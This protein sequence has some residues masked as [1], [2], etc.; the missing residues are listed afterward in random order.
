MHPEVPY[1]V[2]INEAVELAKVLGAE[3][4]HRYF[5]GVLDML[6]KT[7]GPFEKTAS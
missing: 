5:N 3:Q 6:V 4:G 7:L 2:V 1:G